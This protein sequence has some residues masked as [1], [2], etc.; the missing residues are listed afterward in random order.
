MQ[1]SSEYKPRKKESIW[2]WFVFGIASFMF[3]WSKRK[4]ADLGSKGESEP[5]EIQEETH[6]VWAL[7]VLALSTA[8]SYWLWLLPGTGWPLMVLAEALA[9]LSGISLGWVLL[10]GIVLVR[11]SG[12]KAVD[13]DQSFQKD[14]STQSSE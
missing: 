8:G 13:G 9:V 12:K 5:A 10:G 4:L 1:R 6:G 14:N 7:F 2:S 11:E 3:Q